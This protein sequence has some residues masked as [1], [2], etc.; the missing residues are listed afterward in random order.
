MASRKRLTVGLGVSVVLVTAL[1]A[2]LAAT[3]ASAGQQSSL[4]LPRAQTL[5]TS[6]SAWGPFAS[7]NPLRNDKAT[8][9]LGL[10]YETPFRYDP[11]ADKY[12]PWLATSGKWVGRTYVMTL[13]QGVK[14][15]DGKPFTGA[16]VKF[17]YETGKLE[18]SQFS[19]M[20]KTGLSNIVVKGNTVSF[21]FKNAPNY[22]DW[23]TNIYSIPIVPKHIW[24]SY[25]ATDITTGNTDDVSKMVGTGPFKYGAGKGTS[26]TLQWNRRDNWWA[27]KAFGMKMP[28]KYIVDIHNTQNTASL[29][30]FLKNDIDLSNNFFP[31]IDKV[32]GGKVQ[33]YYPKAPFML[34]AN[35]AWLV[36]NTTK[37]PLNDRAFRRAL[38]MSINV[39]QI[40]TADYGNIV[41]KAN[42]TGLLPT[43]NKWIDKAQAAKL[44]FKYN[45]AG[46]KALLAAN[47][48]KDTNGDG[49]VEDKN[50]KGINLRIIVP[51]GWSDWMTAIQIISASAKD[52]G[53]KVTPAYPDY[54]GLVDERNSG[55]FDLVVNNDKQLG[56]TPYTYYDYLFHLPI[57]DSQTF[58]NYA[59]YTASGPKP[60]AL[61]LALNKVPPTKPATAKAIHSKIQKYILEELPAIPL[62]YNGMWSQY[63]TTYWTN[64]PKSTGTGLQNTN[65]VWN[66]YINMT[67]I[68]ALAKLK[69]AM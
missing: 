63:N 40:V 58:A 48:Y 22:L 41:A 49:Y 19:T 13:R 24:S 25:S 56:P 20:W 36:P 4:A 12:I 8:G 17:T 11:L 23:D 21:V 53:I 61:T 69:P 5:Y 3:G 66:G 47:G 6:G 67:T 34:S 52:A 18:G 28:M 45:V 30:N 9:V 31:G 37:V 33:T 2:S 68:D 7:F 29:Q 62:W 1:I 51:N 35:T 10:L 39:D 65:V 15:N 57:A 14:W 38:A 26:G 60:W 27:T 32:I 44:G 46:A 16:D 59:R 55:K 50:G 43:W 54:N 64:F 42:P